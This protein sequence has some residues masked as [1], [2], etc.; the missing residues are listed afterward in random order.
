LNGYSDTA[1]SG[2]V[3]AVSAEELS[4]AS[5]EEKL[6]T[7]K[8]NLADAKAGNMSVI[9]AAQESAGNLAE[10][11]IKNAGR[12]ACEAANIAFDQ[13]INV[14]QPTIDNIVEK[15]F[16]GVQTIIDA[17]ND[18]AAEV[19]Q[20]IEKA[21]DEVR[22]TIN[23]IR[24][25]LSD[26]YQQIREAINQGREDLADLISQL[27][28]LQS[29]IKNAIDQLQ[30]NILNK[31]SGIASGIADQVRDAIDQLKDWASDIEQAIQ[32]VKDGAA[33]AA[34]KLSKVIKAVIDDW[35]DVSEVVHDFISDVVDY[36]AGG[37]MEQDLRDAINNLIAL[38]KEG[39]EKLDDYI[40]NNCVSVKETLANIRLRVN[41]DSHDVV[42][43]VGG[44]DYS[45]QA[46][47]DKYLNQ[48]L[49]FAD[50]YVANI[51]IDGDEDGVY[52]HNGDDKC[53]G[54]PA[55]EPVDANGCSES[56]KDDDGD[57]VTNDKDECPDV[58]GLLPNGCNPSDNNNNGGQPGNNGG[59]QPGGG[60][61][62][63]ST[64]PIIQNNNRFVAT[65][66]TTDEADDEEVVETEE[67]VAEEVTDSTD[68]TDDYASDDGE[69]LGAEDS[70][71]WSVANLILAIGTVLM[72]IIVLLGYLGK[73]KDEE[74]HG[75]LR[76]LTLIPA[77]AAV[78]AFFLTEDW[79]LPVAV[80]DVWTIL[81]VAIMAVGIVLTVLAVRDGEKE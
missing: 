70:K 79:S 62:I 11:P 16:D 9:A 30:N 8:Q 32:D 51:C 81:M 43:T 37:G 6:A 64:S 18:A 41:N 56:Q 63:S 2:L 23:D 55:G 66:N 49:D 77:A 61:N 52:D 34:E 44:K 68:L 45:L 12:L 31:I 29:R 33:K 57:N 54:T 78:V 13:A 58:K 27:E 50:E 3:L 28:D 72:S 15:I 1:R 20:A 65:N 5:L 73:D 80:F 60:S 24:D 74:K 69:V 26:I 46:F 7:A 48:G 10:A 71:S 42:V 59:V 19:R 47:V 25:E 39:K 21:I 67:P 75:A 38:A 76:A 17:V 40:A 14:V 35:N 4:V 36:I 53:L 22:A